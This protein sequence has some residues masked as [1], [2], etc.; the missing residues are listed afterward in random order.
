MGSNFMG[1]AHYLHMKKQLHFSID[2]IL[3]WN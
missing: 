1:Y 2:F 3:G